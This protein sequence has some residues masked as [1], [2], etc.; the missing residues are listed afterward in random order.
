LRF[1]HLHP[2]AEPLVGVLQL[3]PLGHRQVG[4]DGFVRIHPRVDRVLNGEVLRRAHHV[5]APIRPRGLR[6][7]IRRITSDDRHK[8]KFKMAFDNSSTHFRYPNTAECCAWTLWISGSFRTWWRTPG[9]ATP[10]SAT[11]SGSPPPR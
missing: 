11:R 4:I 1:H 7:R 9:P 2:V 5:M 8:S 6:A 3:F 10:K